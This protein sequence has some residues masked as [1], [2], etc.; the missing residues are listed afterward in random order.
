MKKLAA[1]IAVGV[2][3]VGVASPAFSD[4]YYCSLIKEHATA[5]VR[6]IV[7]LQDMLNQ[8]TEKLEY[9]EE[10]YANKKRQ[11]AFLPRATAYATIY[12]AFCK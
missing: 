1:Y 5:D 9:D 4:F 3:S 10:Y 11:D 2:F 7:L 6:A 8:K 12:S